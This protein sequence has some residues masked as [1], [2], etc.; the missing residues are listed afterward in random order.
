LKLFICNQGQNRSRT[1]SELFGGVYIGL[2]NEK[3]LL[4]KELLE[5]AEIVY[6]F[7]EEQREKIAKRFPEQYVKKQIINLNI[8]DIYN[9]NQP[10]LIKIL[11]TN[12]GLKGGR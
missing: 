8:P 9:Y 6:V 1:A 12:I 3:N 7:E 4:T 11:K 10:E 5:E 2:Y